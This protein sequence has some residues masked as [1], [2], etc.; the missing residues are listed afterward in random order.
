ME[1]VVTP[2]FKLDS[3]VYVMYNDRIRKAVIKEI[4]VKFESGYTRPTIKYK[5]GLYSEDSR[6][7]RIVST[8]ET[9]DIKNKIFNT[10][11]E[12]AYSWLAKQGLTP[13]ETLQEFFKSPN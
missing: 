1:L 6:R 13:G 2:K 3:N 8:Y 9:G 7:S 12:A 5:F 4:N 10:K 11:K